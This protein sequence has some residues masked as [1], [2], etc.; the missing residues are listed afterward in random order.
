MYKLSLCS[1]D[2]SYVVST[3][4]S[5][6][7]RLAARLVH[8]FEYFFLTWFIDISCTNTGTDPSTMIASLHR[9]VCWELRPISR[10]FS[11]WR[12]VMGVLPHTRTPPA[13][14][15]RPSAHHFRWRGR[16]NQDNQNRWDVWVWRL[17]VFYIFLINPFCNGS[18]FASQ[19]RSTLL[20]YMYFTV[21]SFVRYVSFLLLLTGSWRTK[22]CTTRAP[23]VSYT[24]VPSS[25]CKAS[26]TDTS[27]QAT[28]P[29]TFES[30]I[31][32]QM[33]T[34]PL[35]SRMTW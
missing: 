7:C 15:P 3:A 19:V 23:S 28:C 26:T 30:M 16:S 35:T 33:M 2:F 22:R 13:Q 10:F 20:T 24:R 5:Q 32:R 6:K 31:H 8:L 11:N 25:S 17:F 27:P 9:R 12:H 18:I 1:C 29:L 14:L 34:S 4:Y 21:C